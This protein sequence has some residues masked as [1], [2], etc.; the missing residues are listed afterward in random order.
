M[1]NYRQ[2]GTNTSLAATKTT[3]TSERIAEDIAAFNKAGGH[4]ETLGNTPFH[5][6]PKEADSSTNANGN[7]AITKQSADK[8]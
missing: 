1:A 7:A 6:R 4:I 8:K 2:P 5:H 3:L